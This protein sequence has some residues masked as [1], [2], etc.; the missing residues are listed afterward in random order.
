[1]L[2]AI[3]TDTKRVSIDIKARKKRDDLSSWHHPFFDRYRET[4]DA[5][6]G[7]AVLLSDE[8]AL[9]KELLVLTFGEAWRADIENLLDFEY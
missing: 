7:R 2:H 5:G 6:R 3:F 9:I 8:S 4:A 1:M